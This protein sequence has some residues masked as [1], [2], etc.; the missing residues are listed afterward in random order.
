MYTAHC[1]K[2]ITM[3]WKARETVSG[4]QMYYV[5]YHG[6]CNQQPVHNDAAVFILL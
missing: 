2:H 1:V 4:L 6:C 3:Y 5:H